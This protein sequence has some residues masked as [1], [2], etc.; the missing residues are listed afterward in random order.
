[1]M[2]RRLLA[3]DVTAAPGLEVDD[4]VGDLH[5]ALLLQVRQNSGAEKHFALSDPEQ[6]RIQLQSSD[7]THRDT[8]TAV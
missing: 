6:V 1:M 3:G 4:D 2:L 5:V 7:L 8:T